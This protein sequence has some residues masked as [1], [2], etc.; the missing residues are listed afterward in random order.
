[1]NEKSVTPVAETR[2]KNQCCGCA[3]CSDVCPTGCIS[4]QADEEGFCYP[5]KNDAQCIRCGRCETVCPMKN[6]NSEMAD[7]IG[8]SAYAVRTKDESLR[9]S[10]SSGGVFGMLAEKILEE[11]GLV[12]GAAFTDDLSVKHIA[13]DDKKNLKKLLGSKYVQ[14][15]AEGCYCAV[16][17]ALSEGKKVLFSG[18][19]CQNAA[20]L[21]FLQRRPENLLCVDLI[22]HGVPSPD[23]WQ[24]YLQYRSS[25]AGSWPI[26]GSFRDK[27]EGWRDFSLSLTFE[28]GTIYRQPLTKDAYLRLFLGDITLRPACYACHFKGE[29]FSSDLTLADFWGIRRFSHK[30]ND[31]TGVSLVLTHDCKGKNALDQLELSADI[32]PV[33][34]KKAAKTATALRES[35]HWPEQRQQYFAMRKKLSPDQAAELYVHDAV[36]EKWKRIIQKVMQMLRK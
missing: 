15:D 26:R 27:T 14:S 23:V 30:L 17:T 25:C 20:L 29:K 9:I 13:V 36:G 3:A 8:I 34:Y 31:N 22:C 16:K 6:D 33:S 32:L 18:T 19:P 2:E 28:N 5:Q 21:Q 35:A 12:F 1:M 24:D 7:S 10:S 4:M 11:G